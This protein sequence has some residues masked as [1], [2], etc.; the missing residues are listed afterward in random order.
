MLFHTSERVLVLWPVEQL[1]CLLQ[2]APD[3]SVMLLGID[4]RIRPA[5]HLCEEDMLLDFIDLGMRLPQP[6]V[7]GVRTGVVDALEHD[8]LETGLLDQLA[9]C[10]IRETLLSLH[11][12]GDSLPE[13]ASAGQAPEQQELPV[14]A[15]KPQGMHK[16][17]HGLSC[18]FGCGLA[19]V[20]YHIRSPRERDSPA[21]TLRFPIK[22]VESS[23]HFGGPQCVHALSELSTEDPLRGAGRSSEEQGRSKVS[24]RILQGR[25]K[26][27][28]RNL[29]GSS[30]GGA[31]M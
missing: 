24:A 19:F 28:A 7:H 30:K 14:P 6:F 2:A 20:P 13:A 17:L 26:D 21:R 15:D 4:E 12:S 9:P 1:D 8:G 16:H 25:S 5:I 18:R 3:E 11:S 27:Q 23:R 31:R 29:Q 22:I 10:G